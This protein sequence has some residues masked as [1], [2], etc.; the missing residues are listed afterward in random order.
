MSMSTEL[1]GVMFYSAEVKSNTYMYAILAI[2]LIIIRST[3]QDLIH[4]QIHLHRGVPV[5]VTRTAAGDSSP[6][7]FSALTE[8]A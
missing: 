8:N 6:S 3:N 7:P 4:V 2:Q 5:L 1:I